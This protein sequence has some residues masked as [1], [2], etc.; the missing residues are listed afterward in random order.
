MN[1][2]DFPEKIPLDREKAVII[3]LPVKGMGL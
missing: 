3:F 1:L 2:N